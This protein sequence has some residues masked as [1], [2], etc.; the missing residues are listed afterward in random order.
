MQTYP[1][2]DAEQL[3]IE[4]TESAAI[5][6]IDDAKE[7]L[8]QCHNNKIRIALDDF[9]TGYSSLTYLRKLPISFLKI[10]KSFIMDM[11]VNDEDKAIVES[12]I[13]LADIFKQQVVAEGIESQAHIE[14]LKTMGCSLGQGY[15]ISKPLPEN[16]FIDWLK[17]HTAIVNTS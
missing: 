4:I 12:I 6:N 1:E 2:V 3:I 16:K 7:I 8:Q 5:S 15:V 10:D 9:G 13:S 11:L 17:N 14:A